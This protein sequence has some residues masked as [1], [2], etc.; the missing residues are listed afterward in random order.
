MTDGGFDSSSVTDVASG[1]HGMAS[2][3]ADEQ[4]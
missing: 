2:G 4:E 1:W 3:G